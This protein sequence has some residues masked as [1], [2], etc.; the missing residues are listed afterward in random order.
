MKTAHSC[1]FMTM[2]MLALAA[3]TAPAAP[4]LPMDL[5]ISAENEAVCEHDYSNA[6]A[7]IKIKEKANG[8]TKIKIKIKNAKPNH[9]YTVWLKLDG[10]SPLSGIG[11]TPAAGS[12][13]IQTIIDNADTACAAGANAFYT[14]SAGKGKL[15]ITLDF[16]LSDGIY[17][18]SAFDGSP[19]VAIGN[20]PFSFRVISH[21]TDGQQHGLYPGVHEPT[22]QISI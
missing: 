15:R 12:G 8:K 14:N 13:D 10:T 22:F 2:A 9:L 1:G 17:P 19:D 21:C 3:T 7:T 16:H 20:T 5:I 6:S 18:F 11:A 4:P